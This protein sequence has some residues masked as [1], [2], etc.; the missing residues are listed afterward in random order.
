MSQSELDAKYPADAMRGKKGNR[1]QA[2]EN[3]Q[4]CQ[5]RENMQSMPSAGKHGNGAKGGKRA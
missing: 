2:R 4:R 1:Y 3:M 5:M